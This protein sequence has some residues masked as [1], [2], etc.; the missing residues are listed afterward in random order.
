MDVIYD[1][2]PQGAACAVVVVVG[3]QV[4]ETEPEVRAGPPRG[5]LRVPRDDGQAPPAQPHPE[6]RP[7]PARLRHAAARVCR[8]GGDGARGPTQEEHS[9]IR[10]GTSI[11]TGHVFNPRPRLSESL[12]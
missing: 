12:Q 5:A 1:N 7:R 6:P 10:S 2:D 9:N 3:R 4:G 8:I 11:Q